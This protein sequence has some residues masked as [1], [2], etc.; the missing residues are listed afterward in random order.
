MQKNIRSLFAP[1]AGFAAGLVCGLL[2]SGGGLLLIPVLRRRGLSSS[3]SHATLLAITVPLAV[4]SGLFYLQ[5][6]RFHWGDLLRYL[7]GGLA[8]ALA[9]AF[10]LPRLRPRLLR[11]IFA[12]FLLYSGLRI[13][14][15]IDLMGIGL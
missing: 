15:I 10:L 4:V 2:G 6:G 9:G 11:G 14:G 12:C 8:G 5:Q 1:A 3:Q 13:S 7:P